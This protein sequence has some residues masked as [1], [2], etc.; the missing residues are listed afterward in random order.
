MKTT[1]AAATRFGISRCKSAA[2]CP[3]PAPTSR[4]RT[5]PAAATEEKAPVPTSELPNQHYS[6]TSRR[7]HPHRP[8]QAS[9]TP[10]GSCAANAL[11]G[12]AAARTRSSGPAGSTTTRPTSAGSSCSKA[13]GDSRARP[14]TAPSPGTKSPASSSTAFELKPLPIKRLNSSPTTARTGDLSAVFA[15]LTADSSASLDG[16]EDSVNPP[17]TKSPKPSGCDPVTIASIKGASTLG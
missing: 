9:P 2:S 11:S 8:D 12:P 3:S 17:S 14:L 10:F 1:H 5:A 7:L 15:P 4:S 6:V 16:A 13:T